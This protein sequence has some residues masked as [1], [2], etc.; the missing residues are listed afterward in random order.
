MMWYVCV[1][2]PHFVDEQFLQGVQWGR[3]ATQNTNL[4][5][6]FKMILSDENIH[7]TGRLIL[8]YWKM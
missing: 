1:C 6:L 5:N 2:P 4:I 3:E 7:E 8:K